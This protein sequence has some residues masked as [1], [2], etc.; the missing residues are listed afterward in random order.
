MKN[1]IVRQKITLTLE[2]F[3]EYTQ[4]KKPVKMFRAIGL[5]RTAKKMCVELV[6]YSPSS[7]LKIY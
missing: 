2:F 4:H 5:G 7:Q 1:I 6:K 3:I